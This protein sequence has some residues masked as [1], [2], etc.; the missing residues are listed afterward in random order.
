ME[1]LRRLASVMDFLWL[2][3]K[4]PA[5]FHVV[6]VVC[7]LTAWWAYGIR[8]LTAP[9]AWAMLILFFVWVAASNSW[10]LTPRP[11]RDDYEFSYQY[12]EAW[13]LWAVYLRETLILAYLAAAT[14]SLGVMAWLIWGAYTQT[15]RF[16]MLT[17]LYGFMVFVAQAG[18]VMQRYVCSTNSPDLGFEYQ[19]WAA[20]M[21]EEA[22]ARLFVK[23]LAFMGGSAEP[24]AAVV[25]PLFFPFLTVVPPL[26]IVFHTWR[27]HRKSRQH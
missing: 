14:V 13:R 4:A 25:G 11:D 6:F 2:V 22:C 1:L 26:A 21:N 12:V 18:E 3:A 8:A 27:K 10:Q 5:W 24:V 20:G 9:S 23:L 19:F 17:A 15:V 16:T 7:L